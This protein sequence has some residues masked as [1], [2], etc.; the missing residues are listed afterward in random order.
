MKKFTALILACLVLISALP[1]LSVSA[2]SDSKEATAVTEFPCE[3][4]EL[5]DGYKLYFN[6]IAPVQ[7]EEYFD[8]VYGKYTFTSTNEGERGHGLFVAKGDEKMFLSEAIERGITDIDTAV[9]LIKSKNDVGYPF[10]IINMD[11]VYAALEKRYNGRKFNLVDLGGISSQYHLYY[12]V[13]EMICCW[14]LKFEYSGYTFTEYGGQIGSIIPEDLGLYVVGNGEVY[15]LEEA[16]KNPRFSMDKIV[17]LIKAKDI[18]YSFYVEKTS[19]ETKPTDPT[20]PTESVPDNTD[21]TAT[22]VPT[23]T[24]SCIPPEVTAPT[25]TGNDSFEMFGVYEIGE[26]KDGYK[27]YYRHIPS[28]P[29]MCVF[30]VVYGKYTFTHYNGDG[31]ENLGL[32]VQKGDKKMFL[33]EAIEKGITDI[34]TAVALLKTRSGYSFKIINMDDVEAQLEKRYNGRTFNLVDLGSVYGMYRLYYNVPEM[35]LDWVLEFEYCGYT[36]TEYGGQIGSP[37]PEDLGLYVVGN[38]E[39][40]NL[41]EASKY[42]Y[43]DMNKIVELIKAKDIDYT[44]RVEKTKPTPDNR[45]LKEKFIDYL[46][47]TYHFD[48][49]LYPLVDYAELGKIGNYSDILVYGYQLEQPIDGSYITLGEYTVWSPATDNISGAGLYVYHSD[50]RFSKLGDIKDKYNAS[51]IVDLIRKA[52]AEHKFKVTTSTAAQLIEERYGSIFS[53]IVKLGE[54]ADG[55]NLY[56]NIPSLVCDWILDFEFGDY[57]FHAYCGQSGSGASDELGLFIIGNGKVYNLDEAYNYEIVDIEKVIELIHANSYPLLFTI[58]EKEP[59]TTQPVTTTPAEPET[60]TPTDPPTT[61]PS[62]PDNTPLGKYK[63]F[64]AKN[65]K[66]KNPDDIEVDVF[67]KLKDG[68]YLVHYVHQMSTCAIITDKIDRFSYFATGSGAQVQIYDLNKEKT[69]DLSKAYKKGI[70]NKK[71][72]KTISETLSKVEYVAKLNEGI[73]VLKPGESYS[74]FS[75]KGAKV[76]S[77]KPKVVKV[78]KDKNGNKQLVAMKKGTVKIT[79]K[80]KNGKKFSFNVRVKKNPELTNMKDKKINSVTVKKGGK[81]KVKIVGKVKGI[82]NSYSATNYAKI[83]SKKTADTIT[84]KGL[85]KG[86]TK[87]TIYVNGKSLSL[88]VKVK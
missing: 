24:C 41:E 12:N 45:T 23:E 68:L 31:E 18:D 17:S 15:N 43:F 34:E 53:D 54:V 84:V 35:I 81:V 56:Y 14:V 8:V 87:L 70:I 59:E 21:P 7:W 25:T 6:G 69:Y 62:K 44:F 37:I 32:Y 75:E 10:C 73:A 77:S 13:P 19:K 9:A 33:S 22:S 11:D 82:D 71:D 1:A 74:D 4:G 16:D 47:E 67:K 30:D 58:I 88:N 28:P 55:Y 26:L 57:I 51:D 80:P 79:V 49:N 39:V 60:T 42:V 85:K 65:Q 63:Q 64:L 86:N 78:V 66:D 36:F 2:A 52:P 38:G 29:W 72:L 50:G 20:D 40:F 3:I 27:L 76:T 61:C 48:G 5:N 83:T 46:N